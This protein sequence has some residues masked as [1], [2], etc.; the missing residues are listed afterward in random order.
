VP[1]RRATAHRQD[2]ALRGMI[3]LT[4]PRGRQQALGADDLTGGP[5]DGILGKI[6]AAH[7]TV[8]VTRMVGT[9]PTDDDNVF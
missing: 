4:S 7:S 8:R 3:G 2:R 6:R 1:L 5:L 9:F